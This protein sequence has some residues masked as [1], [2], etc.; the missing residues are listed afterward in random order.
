MDITIQLKDEI[1]VILLWVGLYGLLE[2]II[3]SSFIY[4]NKNY[5]YM[6]FV[7]ISLFIKLD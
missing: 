7:L 1:S 6:L 3:H 4:P 2:Q 5:I